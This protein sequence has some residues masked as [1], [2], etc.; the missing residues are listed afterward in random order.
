MINGHVYWY[1]EEWSNQ[2]HQ[3]L[4]RLTFSGEEPTATFTSAAGAGNEMSFDAAGSTA[5]G[6]VARYNW[7]FNDGPGGSPTAPTETT[8]PTVSHT[9]PVGGQIRGR[10]H[11]LRSRRYEHRHGAALSPWAR[12][13]HRRSPK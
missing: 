10:A 1:Q 8:G 2:T 11:G 9:F 13:P 3:C 4:Q 12:R 6:G 5:P 7:Q